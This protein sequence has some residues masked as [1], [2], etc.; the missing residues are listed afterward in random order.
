MGI[1]SAGSLEK[2]DF[3]DPRQPV[4][5]VSW[6]EA[7]AYARWAGRALPTESQWEKAARGA[8]GRRYPWGDPLPHRGLCNFD[9]QVGHTTKA[10]SY[11]NGISPYG[12]EDM[13]GNVNNWCRDWYGSDVYAYAKRE[14]LDRDP[15]VDS[16]LARRAD[17]PLVKRSD[18]GG[19]FATPF[20][21]LEVLRCSARLGWEP[22]H[23]ELW[24]GFRTVANLPNQAP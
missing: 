8:D 13:A 7:D 24:N 5:G 10:G 23:R 12:C 4:S 9:D 1:H 2:E 3:D 20:R 11:P 21:Y 19:G 16:D 18:R 17:I 15:F 14:R 22:G 6:Y